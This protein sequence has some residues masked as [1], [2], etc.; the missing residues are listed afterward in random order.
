MF[1]TDS[2][3]QIIFT[4]MLKALKILVFAAFFH[5][6]LTGRAQDDI[7]PY[8][9]HLEEITWPDWPGLHSFAFA[10]WNGR[11]FFLCGRAGGMHGMIPPDPFAQ[12][13]ANHFIWMMDPATGEQWSA[14]VYGL[15]INIADQLRSTNP[16]YVQRNQYL[17]IMGGYGL[18]STI[19]DFITFPQML[20]VDLSVLAS[21]LENNLTPAPAFRVLNDEL[22]RLCGAE[23]E[24]LNDKVYLFGGHDFSGTYTQIP[25][26]MFSQEYSNSLRKFTIEDDGETISVNDVEYILDAENFH[27]RDLNFEPVIY[28]DETQG[29]AAYS[30]VFQYDMNVPWLNN[31]Y[32]TD[33]E[34]MV[35]ID[36][37]H[38]FSNYTCPVMNVYDSVSQNFYATFFG[39]ISQY[40]FDVDDATVYEDLNIPFTRDI[41]TVIRKP[42]NTVSQVLHTERFESLLGS[43]AIFVLNND[44]PHYTNEVLQLHNIEGEIFTGYIFGGIEAEFPNFTPSVASNKLFKVMLTFYQ[45]VSVMDS[46]DE[47]TFL[48]YPNPATDNLILENKSKYAVQAVELFNAQGVC[49]GKTLPA[50]AMT[51]VI[52]LDVESLSPGIYYIIIIT[53][54]IPVLRKIIIQ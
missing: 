9:V 15:E 2:G 18:D 20:A 23:A 33:S 8:T 22:F 37:E 36:F 1:S 19:N 42:D 24:W 6:W 21:A 28:A 25:S 51:N 13:E 17:Y 3:F 29:L 14:N 48:V 53:D 4:A 12:N 50:L 7:T 26:P 40:Y 41:S 43:N 54:E 11:W 44:V 34:Y 35:D 16:Q 39:G 46:F 31:I 30:G 45:P 32:F 10:E 52:S 5:F 49:M 38:R 27:R 47:N